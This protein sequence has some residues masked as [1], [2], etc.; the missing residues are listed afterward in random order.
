MDGITY[1]L[2]GAT[3]IFKKKIDVYVSKLEERMLDY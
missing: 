3:E 1:M 2:S